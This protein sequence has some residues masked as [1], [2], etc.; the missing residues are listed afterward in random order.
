MVIMLRGAHK[1]SSPEVEW[2]A[3]EHESQ[4]R[5]PG[6]YVT[7]AA[8]A[9]FLIIISFYSGNP[10]F[11]FFILVAAIIIASF[12]R[13]EPEVF[14]FKIDKNGIAIGEE[15]FHYYDTL[16]GFGVLEHDHKLDEIVIHKK[17]LLA[18][19]VKIPID[20]RTLPQAR[21]ILKKHLPE[22]EYRES[23]IDI[24]SEKLKI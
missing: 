4:E 9:V 19:L 7:L 17:R 22:K 21:R 8:S 5:G 6:W 2:E 1:S 24:V 15:I 3:A 11:A 16:N 18:P 23:L 20:S 10:L 14:K 13:R 12:S